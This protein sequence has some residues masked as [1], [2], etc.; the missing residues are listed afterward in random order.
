[1]PN[2]T[3]EEVVREAQAL[4]QQA[5]ARLAAS[6]PATQRAQQSGAPL[7]QEQ[8]D[9]ALAEAQALFAKDMQ[10]VEREVAEEAARLRFAAPPEQRSGARKPRNMI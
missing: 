2:K 10:D 1:M 5:Q 7:T 8:R 3:P 6:A 4:V 9:K